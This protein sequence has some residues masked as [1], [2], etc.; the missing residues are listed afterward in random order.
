M[1]WILVGI[2]CNH[3]VRMISFDYVVIDV[4]MQSYCILGLWNLQRHLKCYCGVY[5]WCVELEIL[6]ICSV[7]P[8]DSF[9]FVIKAFL[10]CIEQ[11]VLLIGNQR[12]YLHG[13]AVCFA[14]PTIR[15]C[16]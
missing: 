5:Q 12:A 16:S 10:Y 9:A 11:V 7:E 6:H 2:S 1:N 8:N 15:F 14:G 13:Q 3:A 4:L